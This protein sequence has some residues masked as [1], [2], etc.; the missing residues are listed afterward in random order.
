LE[1]ADAHKVIWFHAG[2]GGSVHPPLAAPQFVSSLTSREDVAAQ[3]PANKNP[4][5][6]EFAWPGA[7]LPA[8]RL[9]AGDWRAGGSNYSR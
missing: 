6:P 9:A 1:I 4:V 3:D 5:L 2:G 8:L 7:L